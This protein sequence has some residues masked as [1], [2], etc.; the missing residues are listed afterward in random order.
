MYKLKKSHKI[1][2]EAKVTPSK[3]S[4]LKQKDCAEVF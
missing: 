4:N 2:V 3:Q 1:H